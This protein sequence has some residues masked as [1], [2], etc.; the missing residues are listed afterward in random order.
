MSSTTA[1]STAASLDK[2]ILRRQLRARRRALS[3]SRQYRAS[4]RLVGVVAG[5]PEFVSADTMAIYLAADGEIDTRLL[6]ERAWLLGKRVYLPILRAGNRLRFAE[7]RPGARLRRN[8]LG[9]AEPTIKRFR[10]ARILDLV[11]MP[12][13]GFDARGGR[14]GMGGGFYDRSFAFLTA[15]GKRQPALV[16][17]AHQ[18]QQVDVLP[19]EPWDVPMCAVATDRRWF[20]IRPNSGA[21]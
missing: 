7:F 12:L 5:R 4:E 6:I 2:K 21:D 20:A 19:V 3:H 16:G 14:L 1:S 9:I 13:V 8:R 18:F 15:G 17:L 11:L 10:D